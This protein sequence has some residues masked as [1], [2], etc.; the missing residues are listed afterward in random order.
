MGAA[1]G[2]QA[3][4]RLGAPP[5][6]SEIAENKIM[7]EMNGGARLRAAREGVEA[8][9][10]NTIYRLSDRVWRDRMERG[11]TDGRQGQHDGRGGIPARCK[12]CHW[13][14]SPGY[15]KGPSEQHRGT[16]GLCPSRTRGAWFGGQQDGGPA[17][18]RGFS[19]PHVPAVPLPRPRSGA[20]PPLK[21]CPAT[22]WDGGQAPCRSGAHGHTIAPG[23]GW[24]AKPACE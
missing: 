17:L 5:V 13:D 19:H 23:T 10:N 6:L 21:G 16:P 4:S 24:V 3:A 1:Q 18:I 20:D 22:W 2:E 11:R 12:A 9:T 8:A 14:T 15:Q 7:G